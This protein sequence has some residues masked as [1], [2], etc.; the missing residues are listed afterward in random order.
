MITQQGYV[1]GCQLWY[2]EAD[3]QPGNPE[4]GE[5]HECH[6]PE[7]KCLGGTR[8]ILLLKEHHAIQGVLQSEEYNH[9]CIYGWEK[10]YCK[11]EYEELYRKWKLN[12]IKLSHAARDPVK[13]AEAARN[14]LRNLTPE[15]RTLANRN[16]HKTCQEK[17]IAIW[18][19]EVGRK[20]REARWER[21]R[22]AIILV[23]PDGT[24]ELWRSAKDAASHYGITAQ[25]LNHV[26]KGRRKKVQGFTAR[27]AG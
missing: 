3:L 17:K 16:S 25:N 26:L 5:W 14:N 12:Q 19:P 7:P 18:D 23:H 4:D 6:Y 9:P 27:Y 13:F 22:I 11:G 10:P 2:I 21:D 15:Q 1:E 24:E 20:G 8:T